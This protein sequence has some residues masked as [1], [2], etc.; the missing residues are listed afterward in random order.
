MEKYFPRLFSLAFLSKRIFLPFN[1]FPFSFFGM[2]S[3]FKWASQTICVEIKVHSKL[4][5]LKLPCSV[6]IA[7]ETSADI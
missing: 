4:S 3:E 1:K 6:L 5:S 2:R 7:I